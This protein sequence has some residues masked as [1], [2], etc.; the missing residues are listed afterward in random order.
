MRQK[1]WTLEHAI[2][3]APAGVAEPITLGVLTMEGAQ[4]RARLL[5]DDELREHRQNIGQAENHVR[6]FKQEQR[7]RATEPEPPQPHNA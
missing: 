1:G 7:P 5:T 4:P 6:E 3:T 2:K